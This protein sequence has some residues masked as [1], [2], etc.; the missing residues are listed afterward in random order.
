MTN[1]GAIVVIP[2]RLESTRL[3]RK[4]LADICGWP[5]IRHVYQRVKLAKLPTDVL[6]ATDSLEV[7]ENVASWGGNVV[8]TSADCTCGT[9][10]I[11]SIIEQLE[12]DIIVNVQGDEPLIEPDLIDQLIQATQT[13]NADVVIPVRKISSLETLMSPT[14]VKAVLKPTGEVIYFSRNASPFIRDVAPERWLEFHNY[15]LVVG[16]ASFRASALLEYRNWPESTLE[17]LEKI[18]QFRFLEAGKQIFAIET[19]LDSIAVDVPEDLERA[20]QMVGE[21]AGMP[22]NTRQGR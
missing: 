11:A 17:K 5:M 13:N 22:G 18:E 8:M 10:R 9:E 12:T 16:T 21:L 4:V 7:A 1:S 6:V 15:W 20:R 2:A 19:D 14:A 3:P